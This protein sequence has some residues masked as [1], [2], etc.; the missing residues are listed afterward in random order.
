MEARGKE[1]IV[2]R[3]SNNAEVVT[4]HKTSKFARSENLEEG[5]HVNTVEDSTKDRPLSH[6]IPYYEHIRVLWPLKL[7]CFQK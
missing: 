4:I 2:I 3:V 6:N 1:K 5:I 7:R